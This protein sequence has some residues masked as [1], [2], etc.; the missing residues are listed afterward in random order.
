MRQL[1]TLGLV[2]LS[3]VGLA[4][5]AFGIDDLTMDAPPPMHE[6]YFERIGGV[7]PEVRALVLA[8]FDGQGGLFLASGIA[9]L[10]LV[11]IPLRRGERWALLPA[12]AIVV[13]GYGG[14][15]MYTT[16]IGAGHLPMDVLLGMGLAGSA[17]CW[18][19]P[20]ASA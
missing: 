10:F 14:I 1:R 8:A 11:A 2:L 20:R 4:F 5:L 16:Q 7:A 18:R 13:C 15:T 17:L 9:L 3:L 12:T 19:A 6:R